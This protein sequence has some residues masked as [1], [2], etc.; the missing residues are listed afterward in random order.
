[1]KY[2]WEDLYEAHYSELL[3]YG[4]NISGNKELSED[5]VQ[6]TFIRAIINTAI[7]EDLT[8]SKKRAWLFRTFKNLFY[9]RYRHS[10]IENKYIQNLYTEF[11]EDQGIKEIENTM[12]LQSIT[13]EDRTLFQL[14]YIEGFTA[15]EISEMLNIPAGTI[16]SKLSR[17]RQKLKETIEL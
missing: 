7:L 11:S 12:F 14:R 5:L 3:A 9:D 13:P 4:I 17:C 2:L 15:K 16:R 6:E 10:V 8:S 1:M